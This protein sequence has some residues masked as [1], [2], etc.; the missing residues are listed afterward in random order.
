MTRA[1]YA[2]RW[3][4]LRE[5]SIFELPELAI[6][7]LLRVQRSASDSFATF[8]L[9]KAFVVLLPLVAL[10][11]GY[12]A[13]KHFDQ[14]YWGAGLASLVVVA[15]L[16]LPTNIEERV[17][18]PV[19]ALL[20]LVAAAGVIYVFVAWGLSLPVENAAILW[21]AVSPGL[22]AAAVLALWWPLIKVNHRLG[23]VDYMVLGLASFVLG[24]S[25]AGTAAALLL[26]S[27]TS[28]ALWM[29]HIAP[30][31]A[32]NVACD[33]ATVLATVLLMRAAINPDWRLSIPL[34]VLIDVVLA[35]LLACVSVGLGLVGSGRE[36]GVAELGRLLIGTSPNEVSER[37]DPLFWAMHTT[38]LPTAIYF[39]A[40]AGI[41]SA[42]LVFLPLAL[43]FSRSAIVEKPH[44]LMA[45]AFGLLAAI[46]L[47]LSRLIHALY[48]TGAQASA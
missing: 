35:A 16:G 15:G 14:P 21:L 4:V 9:D 29:P 32:A 34:A 27:V 7:F 30:M 48:S 19:M 11:A 39:L 33:T 47:G 24:M 28:S 22:V 25:P 43:L 12:A 5:R 23:L 37:F 42:R 46:C 10:G 3:R 38:F 44:H 13:W 20:N 17:S 36:L 2:A 18:V 26:G 40:I 45:G 41:W 1:R 8:L 6:R 31:Y